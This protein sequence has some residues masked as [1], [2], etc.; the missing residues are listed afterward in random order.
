MGYFNC[1]VR[2]EFPESKLLDHTCNG[3]MYDKNGP[4]SDSLSY[5]VILAK[6]YLM[7]T[8]DGSIEGQVE[9]VDILFDEIQTILVQ[10]ID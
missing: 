1:F 7:T 8:C 5:I 9:F 2:S 3:E 6:G 10:L 4:F